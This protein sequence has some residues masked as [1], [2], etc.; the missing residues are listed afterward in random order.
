MTDE[1]KNI[2]EIVYFYK[3]VSKDNNYKYV[4]KTIN[5]HKRLA[6]HIQAT[7]DNTKNKLKLYKTIIDNNYWWN[8]EMILVD[9]KYNITNK[10]VQ[11]TEQ[12]YIDFYDCNLNSCRAKKHI[13]YCREYQKQYAIENNDKIKDRQKK[14]RELN[15]ATIRSINLIKDIINYNDNS[16]DTIKLY[17]DLL[18]YLHIDLK[19][20]YDK[21]I[22]THY[23]MDNSKKNN[24]LIGF[25]NNVLNDNFMNFINN[26]LLIDY[27]NNYRIGST[28]RYNY[29]K[30]DI[31]TLN[32]NKNTD[33]NIIKQLISH[34]LKHLNLCIKYCCN[35]SSTGKNYNSLQFNIERYNKNILLN[36]PNKKFKNINYLHQEQF[37]I[38]K[39]I[40]EIEMI[41]DNI[42]LKPLSLIKNNF[43]YE[44]KK[45]YKVKDIKYYDN[46]IELIKQEYI[47][48]NDKNEKN[49]K[50]R[51]INKIN[52]DMIKK[53]N[54]IMNTQVKLKSN[55]NN[56]FTELLKNKD[57]LIIINP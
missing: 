9:T 25:K 28:G 46:D 2:N 14:Y 1:I 57:E 36:Y 51:Y 40:D 5:F 12:Y 19:R 18:K 35:L 34:Y 13:N 39:D 29:K 15:N 47:S 26:V 52:E 24:F 45:K 44:I 4:G 31:E 56:V 53:I 10:Q 16:S 7:Y 42:I 41:N 37:I 21:N 27:N 30:I 20:D 33:L 55:M 54:N 3:I 50:Y 17:N 22:L 43:D 32:K 48:Y 38:Y 6:Q 49:I 23:V 8:F 11:E